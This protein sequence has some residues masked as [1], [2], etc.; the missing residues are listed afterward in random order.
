M[1]R[2]IPYSCTSRVSD[3][4]GR[5]SA[6]LAVPADAAFAGDIPPS[7]TLGDGWQAD[8]VPSPYLARPKA[9]VGLGDT[10]VAGLMLAAGME[11]VPRP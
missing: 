11:T 10:F 3:A 9:T 1:V 4:I 6:H 7:G 2:A 8:C 5:P